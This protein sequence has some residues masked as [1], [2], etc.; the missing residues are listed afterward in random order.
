[1][2]N[3][4]IEILLSAAGALIWCLLIS[5]CCMCIEHLFF[6]K[7]IKPSLTD[8]EIILI[9][10]VLAGNISLPLVANDG[11]FV[12]CVDRIE[13]IFERFIERSREQITQLEELSREYPVREDKYA[14]VDLKTYPLLETDDFEIL[15]EKSSDSSS[16]LDEI[17]CNSGFDKKQ[18]RTNELLESPIF[19]IGLPKATRNFLQKRLCCQC[20]RDI[21][22]LMLEL[23]SNQG[24]L[25]VYMVG[26]VSAGR[27]ESF[28]L[29]NNLMYMENEIY[30]LQY[31]DTQATQALLKKIEDIHAG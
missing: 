28:M 8:K 24:L 17:F 9:Q 18:E 7:S 16:S 2:W 4:L 21:L 10:E 19:V 13:H 22:L 1:M 23:R 14:P 25:E 29:D 12:E 3:I 11:L 6:K 27:L 30:R 15:Q 20:V 5:F 31:E 26:P